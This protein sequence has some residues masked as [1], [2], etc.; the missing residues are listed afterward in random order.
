LQGS[1]FSL[2]ELSSW[3][4]PGETEE[5]PVRIAIVLTKIQA[6]HLQN[7]SLEHYR[8]TNHLSKMNQTITSDLKQ[9]HETDTL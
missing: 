8:Y 3:H 5:K 7:T 1:S 2:T 4:L 6:Q 9:V